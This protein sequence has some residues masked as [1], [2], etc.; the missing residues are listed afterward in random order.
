[1]SYGGVQRYRFFAP[2]AL[3]LASMANAGNSPMPKPLVRIAELEID[4]AQIDAYKRMLTEEIEASVREEPGVLSLNAVSVKGRPQSI[5]VVETYADQAAYEAHL[6]SAHFLKYKSGTAKMVL[7]L[8]L[9][10]A[11]QIVAAAKG[12]SDAR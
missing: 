10:E 11:D 6:R 1:M 2:L 8:V 12:A 9:L 7:S 3:L 5:R 4:P